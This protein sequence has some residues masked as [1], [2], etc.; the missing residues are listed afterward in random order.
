MRLTH[1][2]IVAVLA[3][4][5]GAGTAVAAPGSAPN[6]VGPSSDAGPSDDAGPP[7]SLPEPVPDF[8]GDVL[9]SVTDFLSGSVDHLGE[10]VRS[11]TPGGSGDAPA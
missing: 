4:L 9:G 7:S 3:L 8:V 11:I 2:G 10:V 1:V 6:D 5:V